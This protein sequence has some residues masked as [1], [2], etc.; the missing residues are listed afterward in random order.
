MECDVTRK[1]KAGAQ[2]LL[3]LL[4]RPDHLSKANVIARLRLGFW[5]AMTALVSARCIMGLAPS[6]CWL[7]TCYALVFAGE[8]SMCTTV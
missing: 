4:T 3:W 2:T 5:M 7:E 6:A 1:L 8:P